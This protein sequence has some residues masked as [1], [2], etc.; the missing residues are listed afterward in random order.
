EEDRHGPAELTGDR[1]VELAIAVQVGDGDPVGNEPSGERRSRRLC[2]AA[3]AVAEQDGDAGAK[4]ERAAALDV[5]DDEVE[6]LVAVEVCG[7]D[8]P[9]TVSGRDRRSGRLLE[10]ARAVSEQDRDRV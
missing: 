6:L 4:A 3:P 10:P 5:R 9:G 2:E 1:E 7:D 8:V